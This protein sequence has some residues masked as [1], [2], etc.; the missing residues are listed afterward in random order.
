M[1]QR[2]SKLDEMSRIQSV[3]AERDGIQ[4][5]S[6][7]AWHRPEVRVQ[8]S[9]KELTISAALA[10][11]L[12]NDLSNAKILDVGCGNGGFLRTLVDWG[13]QPINLV[14][15][16]YLEDRLDH[17]RRCSPSDIKWHLGGLEA[18]SSSDFDLVATNTV[19]SSILDGN[20][21]LMLTRDMW[22]VLK[23]GGWLLVFDFRYNNPFNSNVRKVTPKELEN[24]WKEGANSQHKTLLLAPPLARRIIPLSPLLGSFLTKL[25]PFLRSHF[26]FMLQKPK[27]L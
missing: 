9:E 13:A 23:P 25:F 27:I 22:R 17:A 4:K 6:L 15:S 7:Y 19:F 1:T 24:Y 2:D 5:S 18:V 26:C 10:N 11:A 16:E 20:E 12:G 14:G 21:R 3:Y 8:Q